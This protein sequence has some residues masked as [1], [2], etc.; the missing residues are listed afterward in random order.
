MLEQVEDLV[1]AGRRRTG[2]GRVELEAACGSGGE[3]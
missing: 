2:H 3:S 1:L